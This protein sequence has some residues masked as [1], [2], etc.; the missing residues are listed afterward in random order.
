[1]TYA[2]E[3]YLT[4]LFVVDFLSLNKTTIL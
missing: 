1:M 4:G 3:N 2:N